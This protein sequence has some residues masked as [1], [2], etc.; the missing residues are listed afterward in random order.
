MVCLWLMYVHMYLHF[1][2][3]V[4][5]GQVCEFWCEVPLPIQPVVRVCLLLGLLQCPETTGA[6]QCCELLLKTCHYAYSCRVYCT[7]NI[8]WM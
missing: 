3:D 4:S 6:V 1:L 2:F 8:H 7:A 5:I